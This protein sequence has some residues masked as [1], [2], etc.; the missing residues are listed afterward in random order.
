MKTIPNGGER[1]Q[2]GY[3]I[4]VDLYRRF[5]RVAI[6]QGLTLREAGTAAHEQYVAR[7]EGKSSSRKGR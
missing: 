3:Q 6:Q 4:P 2:P 7:F 5:R 1:V